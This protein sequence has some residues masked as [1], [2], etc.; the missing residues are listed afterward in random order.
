MSSQETVEDYE[1]IHAMSKWGG[2][3][4]QALAEAARLADEGNLQR[5]KDAW[6]EY[7][8]EYASMARLAKKGVL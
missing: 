7:W 1:V 5:I 2:H 3:F 8:I 4:A 6:P